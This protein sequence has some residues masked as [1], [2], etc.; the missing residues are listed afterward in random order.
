MAK[1]TT[2]N[3]MK[4]NACNATIKIWKIDQPAPKIEP[5]I[6]PDKPVAAHM[7]NNQNITSPAY[8]L[9]KRRNECDNG[10]ETYSIKLNKKFS[11]NTQILVPKGE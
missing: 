11:G 1:Y 2:V 8:I 3:I 7:P 4:I 9:P 6:V 5:N 10:F